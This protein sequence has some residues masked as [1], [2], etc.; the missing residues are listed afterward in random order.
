MLPSL[1]Q[2]LDFLHFFW[3]SPMDPRHPILR[4]RIVIPHIVK[5]IIIVVF[6]RLV[7]L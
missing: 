6:F 7:L 2:V 5:P 4:I 1:T 3:I